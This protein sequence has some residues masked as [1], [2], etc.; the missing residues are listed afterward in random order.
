MRGSAIPRKLSLPASRYPH[1][2]DDNENL[3]EHRHGA[4]DYFPRI[5]FLADSLEAARK[6]QHQINVTREKLPAG[7]CACLDWDSKDDWSLGKFV[8]SPY[9]EMREMDPTLP[10]S[11]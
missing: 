10:R 2:S 3:P 6:G 9:R 1:F 11:P 4:K 8:E 7:V 5:I